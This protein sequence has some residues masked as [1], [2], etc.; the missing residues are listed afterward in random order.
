MRTTLSSF[1]LLGVVQL[2][3]DRGGGAAR[4]QVQE[5]QHWCHVKPRDYPNRI[6]G[7]KLHISATWLAAPMVLHQAAQVLIAHGC[8]FKFAGTMDRVLELTDKRADRAQAGKFITA[9]PRDDDHLRQLAPLLDQATVQLPGPAI[10]SDRPYREGSLVHYRYGAFAGVPVL[11]NDGSMEARLEAPDGTLVEDARQP[12]FC[13]PP[14]A[15]PPYQGPPGRDAKPPAQPKPV[16]LADRFRVERAITHTARGGVYRATDQHTGEDVIL[17]QARAHI[18]GLSYAGDARDVLRHEAAMLAAIA[19]LAPRVVHEFEQGTQLFVAV[20]ALAGQVLTAWARAWWEEPDQTAP[21]AEGP[22]V[23]EMVAMAHQLADLIDGVHARGFVYR[24]LT[25][26]NVMVLPDGSLR[27]VDAEL[28]A[29]PGDPVTN[30]N[31][32]GFGAPELLAGPLVGPA[33]GPAADHYSLGALL[34]C[35][36]TGVVPAFAPDLPAAGPDAGPDLPAGRSTN[37][38]IAML[39]WYAAARNPAAR[40]LAPAILGLTAPDPQ[41]RW[42]TDRLRE[43]LAAADDAPATVVGS[44]RA[45]AGQAAGVVAAAVPSGT[46]ARLPRQR[47]QL[48]LEG[49]LSHLAASVH[50]A[51]GERIVATNGSWGTR[52]DPCNVQNGAAGVLEV[53]VRGSEQFGWESLRE[54]VARVARWV[55]RRRTAA[56]QLLPGLYFGRAGTAWALYSAARHLAD[57]GLAERALALAT[58]LPVRWPNPDVTHGTAGVGLASLHLW[59]ETKEPALWE[60]VTTAAD[61]LLEHA[62]TRDGQIYWQVEPDFDSK[63]AGATCYGFAHGIAGI[64]TFLL[65]AAQASGRDDC[66]RAAERAGETLAAA[67]VPVA[68]AAYWPNDL[69]GPEPSDLR[70]QWCHGASGVGTF[71][72]RLWQATGEPRYRELAHLAALMVRRGRWLTGVSACHGLAG[73]GEFLLDLA[74]AADGPYHAWAEEL[75]ACLYVRGTLRHG[76]LVV[77]DEPNVDLNL[78]FNTGLGGVVGYLLRLR[79]GGPR[80]WMADAGATSGAAV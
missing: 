69:A 71:L 44:A 57:A 23:A 16:L 68:G 78:D 52:T 72:L 35:L 50:A 65:A 42:S 48:L 8:A 74:A 17:K 80:W 43:L 3:L 39:L 64:A 28:M 13:P 67:A 25:P 61:H 49:G 37:D 58:S 46:D 10:L 5:D 66:R 76:N 79:Y 41:Q 15:E 1:P 11:T 47:Q 24:D 26:N 54:A 38:R 12:W 9:Y 55:D 31:T 36:A 32:P 20:E 45:A 33:P 60:Q 22:P 30:A 14:W 73:N 77:A 2:L 63:L 59:Y 19:G 29:R 56:T 4:W 53:L 51:P 27:L 34:C 18:S 70:Y 75:A 7:W 40:R 21:E 62:H 6:Q